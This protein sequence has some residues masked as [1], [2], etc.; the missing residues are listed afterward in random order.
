MYLNPLVLK[1]FENADLSNM[2]SMV[3]RG[4]I[5]IAKKPANTN[6]ICTPTV[7]EATADSETADI[8]VTVSKPNPNTIPVTSA[9]PKGPGMPLLADILLAKI[10]DPLSPFFH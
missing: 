5:P 6:D 3:S 10:A 1:I 8:C 4:I 9:A 2:L 7:A